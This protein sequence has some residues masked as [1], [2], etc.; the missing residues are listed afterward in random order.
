MVPYR[1]G[2]VVDTA[3]DEILASAG[4]EGAETEKIYLVDK[5]LEFCTNCR[6]CTQAE[7]SQRGK[8]IIDDDM[9]GILEQIEHSDAIIL[10]SSMNFGTVTAV[11]KRF[12]ER[13]VCFAY[14]PW[15]VNS[16]KVRNKEKQKRGV[17]VSASAA[18]ALIARLSSRL[19]KLLKNASGL[20]GAETIGVLFIG[21]AALQQQQDIGEKARKKARYLGKELARSEVRN[22]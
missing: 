19:V 16:P 13:L 17:V 5:H 12:I 2:G 4:Q 11:M 7:G 10:G 15:G 18:P 8:C 14:W 21:L 22:T 1:K 6:S 3:I 20:L 9:N